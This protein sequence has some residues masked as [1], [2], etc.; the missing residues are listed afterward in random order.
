MHH[1]FEKSV[2]HTSIRV[3]G[4]YAIHTQ[5]VLSPPWKVI[6]WILPLSF[7]RHQAIIASRAHFHNYL[8]LHNPFDES[9]QHYHL[10][11]DTRM[12]GQRDT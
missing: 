4:N 8:H 6:E 7:C 9:I 12:L 2:L 5:E 1:F 11:I 10:F 3:V